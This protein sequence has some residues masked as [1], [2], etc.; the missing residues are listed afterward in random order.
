M[1]WPDAFIILFASAFIF[2]ALVFLVCRIAE[3]D[4]PMKLTITGKVATD[5]IEVEVNGV[6][7]EPEQAQTKPGPRFKKGDIVFG[8]WCTITRI[9]IVIDPNPDTT[10]DIKIAGVD[11]SDGSKTEWVKESTANRIPTKA[12][13]RL[14]GILHIQKLMSYA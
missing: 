3:D 7:F 2:V 14:R 4:W 12:I 6:T 5:S 8:K 9:G 11:L 1:I 10:G 13:E